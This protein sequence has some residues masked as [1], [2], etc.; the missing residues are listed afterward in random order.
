MTRVRLRALIVMVA[1]TLVSALAHWMTP[2]VYMSDTLGKPDLESLFPKDFAGWRVDARAAMVLPS[3]E[4]QALLNSIYNQTLTRT[5]INAAGYRIMLSVAYGGDQSDGT[6]AH[7]PEV[8]YP[9]QGFQITA[10]TSGKL[11]LDGRQVAVRRLMAK[12]GARDEPIT[13][14]LVVGD[15]VSVSRTDQKLTQ[16]RLGLKGLIPDGMLVRVSSIDSNR[17]RGYEQQAIFL[18]DLASEVPPA[19]RDR[20]F[21]TLKS[22]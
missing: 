3:P 2:T 11:I 16:F 1:M 22:E 13:Y 18:A 7:V 15:Q 20:I 4:T 17:E 9:A 21:G 19:G 6:R 14:W 5:Y 10:N 8:C 12:Y